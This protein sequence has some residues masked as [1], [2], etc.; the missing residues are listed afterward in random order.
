[1][2]DHIA[3]PHTHI[4]IHMYI[5]ISLYPIL[6]NRVN[7]PK[8]HRPH[9]AGFFVTTSA[10]VRHPTASPNSWWVLHPT[11]EPRMDACV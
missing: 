10:G 8:K 3:H 9:E 11:S 7:P 1:M 4:Y 6:Y 2:C 5:Y